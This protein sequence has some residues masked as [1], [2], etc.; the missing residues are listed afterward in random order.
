MPDRYEAALEEETTAWQQLAAL[1]R[2]QREALLGREVQQLDALREPLQTQLSAAL[3]ARQR[4]LD[5]RGSA[6]EAHSAAVARQAEET[7]REAHE[8]V[9]LNLQLLRDT[10]SYLQML[11]SAIVSESLPTGYGQARAT[12]TAG[13]GKSRVA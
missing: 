7:L 11:R 9:H 5:C 10:C 2:R 1:A 12:R 13:S 6:T 8:A 3:S 4:S